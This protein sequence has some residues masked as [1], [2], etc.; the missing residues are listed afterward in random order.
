MKN[1]PILFVDIDNTLIP[2]GGHLS[3]FCVETINK[4]FD[5]GRKL[6]LLTGKAKCALD[7]P[8]SEAPVLQNCLHGVSNGGIIYDPSKDECT[9]LNT[10]SLVGQDIANIFKQH[11]LDYFV[12]DVND[13]YSDDINYN[14]EQA[15]SMEELHDP[16]V[17]YKEVI[18]YSTCVKMLTHV[19]KSEV[20]KE[21]YIRDALKPLN[22]SVAI[23]RTADHLLE[24]L[25]PL[26]H[27]G[28]AVDYICKVYGVDPIHCYAVGDS[29]NDLAMLQSVGKGF[30]VSNCSDVTMKAQYSVIDECKNDAVAKLMRSILSKEED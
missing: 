14:R 9:F 4:W 3:P 20:E 17:S 12:F 27:K 11:N 19:K 26:Q 24:Y 18:D 28:S 29:E 25:H 30:V 23:M 15:Y 1:V 21:Q 7:E 10:L 16:K 5:S 2:R 8:L 13:I 22:V 6:V